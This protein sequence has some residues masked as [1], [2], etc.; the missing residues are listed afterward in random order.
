MPADGDRGE[1]GGGAQAGAALP[2]PF[3]R[4]AIFGGGTMDSLAL[5]TARLIGAREVLGVDMNDDRLDSMRVMGAQHAITRLRR[6]SGRG[7]EDCG[8]GL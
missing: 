3:F 6:W 7:A 5:Q 2:A 8:R 1:C 4:M